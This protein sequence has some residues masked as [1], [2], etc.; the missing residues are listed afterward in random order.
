MGNGDQFLVA[1]SVGNLRYEYRSGLL[2]GSARVALDLHH[3]AV[4][5]NYQAAVAIRVSG[6]FMRDDQVAALFWGHVG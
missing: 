5:H 2:I 4:L 6:D 1:V 3:T